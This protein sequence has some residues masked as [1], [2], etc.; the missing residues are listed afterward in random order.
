MRSTVRIACDGCGVEF[1]RIAS[2]YRR[3]ASHYC[4]R[5]CQAANQERAWTRKRR[6][7]PQIHAEVKFARA[8]LGGLARAARLS[9]ERLSEIAQLGVAARRAA[10]EEA[11]R[12]RRSWLG[13][14]VLR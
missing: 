11:E 6:A 12:M 2:E 5:A 4:T 8:Q 10:R 1:D 13:P 7:S 14:V 3:Y 9:R